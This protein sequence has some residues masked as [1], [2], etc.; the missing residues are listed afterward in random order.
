MPAALTAK[1]RVPS[2]FPSL[3]LPYT[4]R[5]LFSFFCLTTVNYYIKPVTLWGCVYLLPI[6]PCELRYKVML[7]A[8][9][10]Y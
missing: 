2:C 10:F 9:S 3:P 1:S 8:F 7:G 4:L 6:S 5:L